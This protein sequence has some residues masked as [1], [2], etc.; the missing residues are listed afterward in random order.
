MNV[1][2]NHAGCLWNFAFCF[3][4]QLIFVI[5]QA[6]NI[7]LILD[8]LRY[9]VLSTS[10]YC[11]QAVNPPCERSRVALDEFSVLSDPARYA[12]FLRKWRDQSN[13]ANA[14]DDQNVC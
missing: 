12:Q 14:I 4:D 6:R 2:D 1:L 7:T 8:A 11:D 13:T 10:R 5:I 9:S 3:D